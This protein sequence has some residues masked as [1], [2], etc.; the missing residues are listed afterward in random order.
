VSNIPIGSPPAPPGRHAAPGGW[1]P[2]PVDPGQERYWDGWQW[3]RNTRPR[4]GRPPMPP[5]Q[6]GGS[7]AP[8]PGY[9]YPPRQPYAPR[10]G[11]PYGPR[12][13]ALGGVTQATH[14]ADGVR[15]AG[16]WWRFLA[17]YLDGMVIALLTLIPTFP[18]YRRMIEGLSAYFNEVVQA[19]QSGQATPPSL[20]LGDVFTMQDQLAITG[21]TLLIGLAYQI[22]FLRW[23]AATPAKLICGLRVVPLD[24][25]HF[26]QGLPWGTAVLRALI[27]ELP[28]VSFFA[29]FRLVDGLWPLWQP[30]RQALHDLACRTQVVKIR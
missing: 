25:G 6:F 28:S 8:P 16:W 9:G 7:A 5:P 12:P 24:Q 21:V 3:S 4:S 19:A 20:V 14:T 23:K 29:L 10:P 15:L 1:Y 13:A 27:W 17:A 11:A 2:D 22:V 26:G 18:I 30:K